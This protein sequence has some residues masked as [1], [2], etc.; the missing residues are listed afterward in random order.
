MQRH[1]LIHNKY[2]IYLIT[3]Y[4]VGLIFGII[5]IKPSNVNYIN[6][7][8]N[9][10]TIFFSN[11]WYVFVIWLFGFSII[12]LFTT[13]LI[14]FFRAFIFGGLLKV[15]AVNNFQ[16]FALMLFIE[17]VFAMPL[18]IIVSFISLNMS[19][20]NIKISIYGNHDTINFN[21][22]IN[23]MIIITILIVI[24]SFIIYLN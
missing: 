15:L 10:F 19:S 13:T 3:L 5:L 9:F 6:S 17:L 16:Q 2:F 14:V 12:G 21:K 4:L 11:Y 24:Y 8:K 7:E 23:L 20:V 1:K 18:L 22:Y